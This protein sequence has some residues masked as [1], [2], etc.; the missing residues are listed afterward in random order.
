MLDLIGKA[1]DDSSAKKEPNI[2]EAYEML[3]QFEQIAHNMK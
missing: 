2:E 3:D 1:C